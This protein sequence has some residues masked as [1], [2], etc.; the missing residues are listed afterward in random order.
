MFISM[1]EK[2]NHP[3]TSG[4]EFLCDKFYVLKISEGEMPRVSTAM[5]IG[6]SFVI[7][8]ITDSIQE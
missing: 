8:V 6:V 7:S 1:K 4:G 3:V 5:F 2:S